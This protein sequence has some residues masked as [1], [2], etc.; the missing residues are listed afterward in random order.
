MK[1]LIFLLIFLMIFKKSIQIE[2]NQTI[3][4]KIKIRS[5]FNQIKSFAKELI[6]SN[7]NTD[8]GHLFVEHIEH[9]KFTC[10]NDG[11][12]VQNLSY[13]RTY[14]GCGAYNIHVDFDQLNMTGITDW[15]T[16]IIRIIDNL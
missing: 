12:P 2:Y 7:D 10:E 14:N 3:E 16:F 5:L 15:Y 6:E 13:N 9:C 4:H 11:V 8:Y 1:Q